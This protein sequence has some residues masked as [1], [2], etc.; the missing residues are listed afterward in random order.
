[1]RRR[2]LYAFINMSLRPAGPWSGF[3]FRLLYKS[4]LKRWVWGP[5]W[6]ARKH[7]TI[8]E[9]IFGFG[10]QAAFGYSAVVESRPTTSTVPPPCPC[11]PAPARCPFLCDAPPPQK[12][13]LLSFHTGDY[14]AETAVTLSMKDLFNENIQFGHFLFGKN[15]NFSD[16]NGKGEENNLEIWNHSSP[17]SSPPLSILSGF[18]QCVSRCLCHCLE[19]STRLVGIFFMLRNHSKQNV[20][21]SFFLSLSLS[22]S[23]QFFFFFSGVILKFNQQINEKNIQQQFPYVQAHFP[24]WLSYTQRRKLSSIFYRIVYCSLRTPG[25]FHCYD[26]LIVH[27]NYR[28]WSS[29]RGQ[30]S[31]TCSTGHFKCR[32]Q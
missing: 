12:K 16:L 24:E 4:W 11:P 9:S 18:R 32:E 30:S 29:A 17:G 2:R 14:R 31:L 1:M 13:M 21:P 28:F 27:I 3:V 7:S 8:W 10:V 25:P 20:I 23:H 15:V 26:K 22:P 6:S 19:L 5:L